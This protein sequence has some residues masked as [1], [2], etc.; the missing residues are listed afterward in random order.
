MAPDSSWVTALAVLEIVLLV[1][2]IPPLR[3]RWEAVWKQL[4][5]RLQQ[6][7]LS[8]KALAG[9]TSVQWRI[10]LS[11]HRSVWI[12]IG[13]VLVLAF[14]LILALTRFAS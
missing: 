9:D 2:S 7:R 13:A 3:D 4:S 6:A 10:Q 11:V 8:S 5:E 14:A 1:L 12:G